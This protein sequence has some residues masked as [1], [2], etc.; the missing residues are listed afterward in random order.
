MSDS[1]SNRTA[2]TPWHLWVIGILG[3]LWNAMGAF[4]YVMTETRNA[5]YMSAFTPEQLDFFYSLP[6]WTVAAW[7]IAVW[8]S[9]LATIFLLLRKGIAVWIY[10]VSFVAMLITTFQNYILSNGLEV[11]GDPFSLFFSGL[12]F[13]IA[14]GL[15][16]YS[17]AMARKGVLN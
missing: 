10:L 11:M 15:I 1:A 4:D 5:S 3:L 13:L 16:V 17:R 2:K 6:A 9:V 7:A 8:G 14:L 12:I